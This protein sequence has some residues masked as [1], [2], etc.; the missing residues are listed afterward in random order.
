M[1]DI[2][3]DVRNETR[4][5][6]RIDHFVRLALAALAGCLI[7]CTSAYAAGGANASPCNATSASS[8]GP[9]IPQFAYPDDNGKAAE[10]GTSVHTYAS[11]GCAGAVLKGEPTT[12]RVQGDVVELKHDAIYVNGVSYGAV[13]PTQT[14]E[15]DV[16]PDK[17]TLLV[18]GKVRPPAHP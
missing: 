11:R 16:T 10:P 17:R 14:V 2:S 15:Y 18:D 8:K 6:T 4:I 3:I 7:A 12:A 5:D 1:M 13:T 9:F